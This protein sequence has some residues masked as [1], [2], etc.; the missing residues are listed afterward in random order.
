MQRIDEVSLAESGQPIGD[1]V[2]STATSMLQRTMRKEDVLYL[3]PDRLRTM[4]DLCWGSRGGYQHA[5]PFQ[6][7]ASK[8]DRRRAYLS[9]LAKPIPYRWAEGTAIVDGYERPGVY[10]CRLSGTPTIPLK[11]GAWNEFTEMYEPIDFVGGEVYTVLPTAEF[12]GYRAM[13]IEIEP[14][15][16][17][18]IT[19]WTSFDGFTDRMYNILQKYADEPDV[20]S[21]MKAIPNNLVGVMARGDAVRDVRWSLE[22]PGDDWNDVI[23]EKGFHIENCYDRVLTSYSYKMHIDKSAW[24]YA[25]NKSAMF[26]KSAWLHENGHRTLYVHTDGA[27]YEGHCE[28]AAIVDEKRP[29]YFKDE[30]QDWNAKVYRAGSWEMCG[31]KKQSGHNE[32][33]NINIR[34]NVNVSRI[35]QKGGE[36]SVAGIYRSVYDPTSTPSHDVS[37]AQTFPTMYA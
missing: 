12:D 22:C 35:R 30:G 16:G 26:E 37:L 3:P 11:I 6:G 34:H 20:L 28:D 24:I 23:D 7:H 13:G 27:I 33:V 18:A 1:T 4:L 8:I 32:P 5:V 10:I 19:E 31:V 21:Y 14:R 36:M 15:W 29:G 9:E 25:S 2:G 17:Y